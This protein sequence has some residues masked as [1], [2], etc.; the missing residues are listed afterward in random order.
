MVIQSLSLFLPFREDNF[1]LRYKY[2]VF[3][4]KVQLF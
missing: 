1:I 3:P 2:T 4:M